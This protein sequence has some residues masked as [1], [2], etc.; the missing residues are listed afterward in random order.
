MSAAVVAKIVA[1]NLSAKLAAAG[2]IF[3]AGT[4]TGVG[5]TVVAA[6]LIRALAREGLRVAGMKP[7]AAG[8]E[9]TRSGMRNED[10]LA[11]AVASNIPVP[12]DS[13]NPYCLLA[14]VSPHIAAAEE[15]VVIDL[16]LI[17]H[18]FEKL[19]QL[20]DAVVVEGA[21]G[22]LAPIG[23]TLTMADLALAL[24]LPVLLVVGLRLGCLNHALLTRQAIGTSGLAFAG[25]VGNRIDPAFA[26]AQENI[27]TLTALLGAEPIALVDFESSAPPAGGGL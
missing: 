23:P 27:D 20:A 7:V 11:L 18:H 24:G 8:S 16:E 26:R 3:V 10:A 14:P 2:G 22:W 4:D 25:W 5:K 1:P 12:Y 13:I 21:G 17:Q 9:Q 15:G 19:R 6:G